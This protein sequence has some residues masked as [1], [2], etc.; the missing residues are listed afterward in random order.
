MSRARITAEVETWGTIL[1][2]DVASELVSE[3]ALNE[4]ITECRDFF[5]LIDEL[6]STYKPESQVSR[7]RRG[8]LQLADCDPLIQQVW[9]LCL[10]A[11]D[12][13]DG[14][15]DP[16]CVEGGFDPSGYVKGW[17]AD[18]AIAKLKAHGAQNIQINCAGDLSLA[19]GYENGEPWNVGIRHPEDAYAIVKTFPI[20]D[21]AIATSGTYERGSHIKDPK[22]GMIAIG[23]RSATVY[24]PDGGIADALA[25]AMIVA[26]RE[27][28]YLFL[29]PELSEYNCWVID[30]HGDTAWSPEKSV[31]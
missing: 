5:Y 17:A 15:F 8:Q 23:A 20:T 9:D 11:R 22:T 31:P 7:L 1:Y 10:A 6:F 4:G 24:G 29:K 12:L 13:S 26:G 16:W 2:L 27:G 21:G 3:A 18:V 14:Y 28:A 30:R 19:G 25:T